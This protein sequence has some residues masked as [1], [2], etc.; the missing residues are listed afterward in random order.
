MAEYLDSDDIR[1]IILNAHKIKE[2]NKCHRC[3][4]TG[5][6]NWNGE[7]GNDEK[8]GALSEYDEIRDE[9]ECENC[10]GVGYVDYLMYGE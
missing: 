8:P 10:D 3:E 4:G 9:G 1:N 5:Y 6:T 7:T 2:F